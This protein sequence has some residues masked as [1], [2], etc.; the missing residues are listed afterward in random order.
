VWS[1]LATTELA[2]EFVTR[3]D[4]YGCEL[5]VVAYGTVQ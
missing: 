3:D 4:F 2:G 5:Q 1:Q